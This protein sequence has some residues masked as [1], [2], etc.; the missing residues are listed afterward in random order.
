VT[1]ARSSEAWDSYEL[2]TPHLPYITHPQELN[3]ILLDIA[4]LRPPCGQD[5]ADE[6]YAA[7]DSNSEPAD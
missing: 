5:D 1:A 6:D 2:D 7:R 4:G 3:A